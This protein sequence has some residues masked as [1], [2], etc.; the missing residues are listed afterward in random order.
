VSAEHV[1]IRPGAYADSVT[2]MQ[3]SAW[4]QAVG[5]VQAALVAMA[6]ELN[7]ALLADLG[8]AAPGDA[9]QHDLLVA[10][11][12]DDAESLAAALEVVD[13]ALEERTAR[14]SARRTV[15]AVADSDGPSVPA[16]TTSSAIA[17]SGTGIALISVPGRYAFAEAVD[18][19][20]QGC[21]VMIFSD[22]VPVEQEIALK[23]MAAER[24]LLVMGPD[25]GTAIVAGVGLG[26][27]N[28]IRPGPIGVVAAS[29]TGA[30]QL[31]CLLDTAGTGCS[32][33]LGLGS[34][35]L[36]AAVGGRSAR[37]ALAA[38]DA[39]PATELVMLL[40]KPPDAAVAA[41]LAAY[42]RTLSK[43]VEFAMIGPGQPDLTSAAETA[44]AAL[45]M[46][47]P[48]WPQWMPRGVAEP[49]VAEP[50]VP[51]PN[52]VSRAGTGVLRGLF[53][54]GTLCG[55]AMAIAAKRLGPIHSNVPFEPDLLVEATMPLNPGRHV[56]IDFGADEMTE[57]RP[58]PMIDQ[59]IRLDHL[60][61]AAADETIAVIMLDV[62]LGYGAHPD[63]AAEIAP[64]VAAAKSGSDI[65][66]DTEIVISLIGTDADPQGL[67]GQADA[68][69]RAG[70]HVFASN[71][72]AARFA[73]DLLEARTA[74]TAGATGGRS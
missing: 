41:D 36:S 54:G 13:T 52:Q 17:R 18:A 61:R 29:G 68:L 15:S 55:E 16:M 49:N 44:L 25:C 38:L 39:D 4:A 31:T 62:V 53:A 20:G 35:D 40:S 21:D 72:R 12:A 26:F 60:A 70:A 71:A 11:K 48:D 6:T 37:A 9:G 66:R 1:Q 2:L 43:R 22:N 34:R 7:L 8:M 46:P 5:G 45:G 14:G 28:A 56:M 58:H 33:V 23:E 73:C 27:A 63:P 65:E 42:A 30:Q 57:G 50:N 64:R 24:D 32:A 10:I 69:A 51:E 3:V 19:L 67:A 59:R 47:I 74:G